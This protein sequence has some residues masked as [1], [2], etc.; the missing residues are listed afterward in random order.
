MGNK[1]T[2]DRDELTALMHSEFRISAERE[3]AIKVKLALLDMKDFNYSVEKVCE[4]YGLKE[5]DFDCSE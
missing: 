5:R 4:L 1:K 3:K 2:K